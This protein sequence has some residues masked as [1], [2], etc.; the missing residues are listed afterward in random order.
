MLALH[1]GSAENKTGGGKMKQEKLDEI[2][3]NHRAWMMG[4][5]G[6]RADLRRANLQGAD[7]QRADLRRANLQ[8]ADLRDA[9]LQDADLQRADLRDANLQGADLD[10]SCWPLWCGSKNVN[11]DLKTIYQLLAHVACLK[12][13]DPNFAKIKKAIIE[14][15]IKSHRADDLGLLEGK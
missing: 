5:T 10:F 8:G 2:L 6:E 7:L 9:D 12:C 3:K 15:A 14:Y 1:F 11:V 13:E 4:E